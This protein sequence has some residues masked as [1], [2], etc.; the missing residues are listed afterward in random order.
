LTAVLNYMNAARRFA[1]GL[2]DPKG[3]RVIDLI[4]KAAHQTSRA[5]QIIRQLR[6]FVEKRETARTIVSMNTVVE[7]AITLASIGSADV[8]VKTS[9][10][11]AAGLPPVLIDKIQVQ[12]VV[13]NLVRNSVEAMQLVSRREL[14]VATLPTA[15][16]GVEVVISDSGPGLPPE[17]ASRLF[18]PFVTTKEKGMG[19]GLSICAS[20]I[21]SH[22]GRIWST[23]QD[24]GG[25]SF[26]FWLPAAE[27][28]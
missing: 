6:E 9:I 21:E 7:E 14:K 18:H 11:L 15:D 22:G 2:L 17:V 16:G 28:P 4:D 13:I 26:H 24:A 12:Q 19:I 5:G 10:E 23:P 3:Q 27:N 20:I 25:A 8:N 1:T